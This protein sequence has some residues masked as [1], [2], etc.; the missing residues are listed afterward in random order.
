MTDL[1]EIVPS[2]IEIAHKIVWASVATV[3]RSGRPRTRVLH[4]YW[5]WDGQM[6]VG[7]VATAPTPLK[8][9]HLK[10]GPYVS[11]RDWAPIHDVAIAECRAELI[12]DDET[13]TR[14]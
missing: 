2:F 4:P 13:R 3:D 10:R 5:E 7:W 9:A 1:A 6:L 8:R 14:V 12:Y 11:C